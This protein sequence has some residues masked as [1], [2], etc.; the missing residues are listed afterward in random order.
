MA[1]KKNDAVIRDLGNHAT[2]RVVQVL[3]DTA[4]LLDTQHDAYALAVSVTGGIVCWLAALHPG[5]QSHSAKIDLV[6]T[7][8]VEIME[9]H[10][11]HHARG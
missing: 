8:L 5:K 7:D 4:G 2:V 1:R 10:R 9:M 11:Q 6:L 3:G